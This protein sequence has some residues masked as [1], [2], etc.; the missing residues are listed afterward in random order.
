MAVVG[1]HNILLDIEEVAVASGLETEQK[2][3]RQEQ[4]KTWQQYSYHD[5]SFGRQSQKDCT[6]TICLRVLVSKSSFQAFRAKQTS[7]EI[8]DGH[9]F[10]GLAGAEKP[11]LIAQALFYSSFYI[12]HPHFSCFLFIIL[13][14]E[15]SGGGV[16]KN[17]L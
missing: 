16:G 3:T 11:F 8:S 6:G 5:A 7:L 2:K 12:F 15:S 4:K 9:M 13:L 17:P 14:L 10:G 1:S